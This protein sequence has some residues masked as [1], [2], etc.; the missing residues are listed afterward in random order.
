LGKGVEESV[1]LAVMT[2]PK[3]ITYVEPS[4]DRSSIITS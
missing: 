4:P 3:M 2:Y 1:G